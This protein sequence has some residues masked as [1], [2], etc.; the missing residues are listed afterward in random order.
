MTSI[1]TAWYQGILIGLGVAVPIGRINV[2]IIRRN[3]GQGSA[4]GMALGLGACSVDTIYIVLISLGLLT[5]AMVTSAVKA[6]ILLAG[7]AIL[8]VMAVL[9]LRSARRSARQA[10]AVTANGSAGPR[11]WRHYL[12]GIAMTATSPWNLVFWIG[13]IASGQ[14]TSETAWGPWPRVFGV[15]CG[16][17][18]WVVALNLALSMGRRVLKP[19]LLL[20]INVLGAGILLYFAGQAVWQAWGLL[21]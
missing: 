3:L 10:A 6:W 7:A 18:G 13:V 15:M 8:L 5:A 21:R 11:A 9:I 12:V 1:F 16:T 4:A 2:E 14:Y 19:A 20:G 17:V